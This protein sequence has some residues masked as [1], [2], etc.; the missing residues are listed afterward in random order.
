MTIE[1]VENNHSFN[2]DELLTYLLR[3]AENRRK[4]AVANMR[5]NPERSERESAM[6]THYRRFYQAAI[7]YRNQD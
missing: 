7:H 3:E 2:M 4:L 6:E 5:T 1:T